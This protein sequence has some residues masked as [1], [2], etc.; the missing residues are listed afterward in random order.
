LAQIGKA[1]AILF[2]EAGCIPFRV[3]RYLQGD[4]FVT[5]IQIATA[6]A[7]AFLGASPAPATWSM[8]HGWGTTASSGGHTRRTPVPEPADFALFA[9]GVVGLIVGRRGSRNGRRRD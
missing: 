2:P 8:P 6:S 5:K 3:G 4:G 7:I 1:L 9:A